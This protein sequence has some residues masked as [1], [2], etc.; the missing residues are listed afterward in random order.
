MWKRVK[1]QNL[2]W[3]RNTVFYAADLGKASLR[4]STSLSIS[5]LSLKYIS[6]G[7]PTVVLLTKASTKCYKCTIVESC[8]GF[9]F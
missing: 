5:V 7:P 3:N 6:P 9:Y 8:R 2:I 4:T 1:M